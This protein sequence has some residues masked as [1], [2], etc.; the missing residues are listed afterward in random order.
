MEGTS[1]HR[2]PVPVAQPRVSEVFIPFISL[3]PGI[4]WTRV[5][6]LSSGAHCFAFGAFAMEDWPLS[7]VSPSV[8]AQWVF[9]K[10]VSLK[11]IEIFVVVKIRQ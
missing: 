8:T 3:F 9:M 2:A 1:L 4:N 7:G 11:F 10:W 6:A 5:N